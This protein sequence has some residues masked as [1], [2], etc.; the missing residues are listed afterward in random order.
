M[1]NGD[2]R[3]HVRLG[4]TVVADAARQFGF[5]NA[6]S[7]DAMERIHEH[8]R[9]LIVRAG[10]DAFAGLND[11]ID[12]FVAAAL[13]CNLPLTVINHSSAQHAFDLLDDS[14]ETKRMIEQVVEFLESSADLDRHPDASRDPSEPR[15]LFVGLGD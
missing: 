5:A 9:M 13:A 10:R 3:L 1:R 11:T 8:V 6:N 2:V 7:Q 12:A 4:T 15:T 14:Q